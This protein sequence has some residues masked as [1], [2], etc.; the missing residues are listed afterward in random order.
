VTANCTS[1]LQ[2]R[3]LV[4]EGSPEQETLKCPTVIQLVIG[5]R[6]W[7]DTKTDWSTDRRSQ[8]NLNLS[9]VISPVRLRPEK[10]CAGDDQQKLKTT[11]P[12]SRQRG[13]PTSTNP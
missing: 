9:E 2:T 8:N 11:D 13:F 3:A 6:W 10:G 7:P 1:K 4:R 12:T 5:H